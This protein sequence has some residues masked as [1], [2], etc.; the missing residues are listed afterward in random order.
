MAIY[1]ST[2][3]QNKYIKEQVLKLVLNGS[4]SHQNF[5]RIL[6]AYPCRLYTPNYFIR[7]A[8]GVL[9]I[10]AAIFSGLLIGLFFESS[11]QAALTGLFLFYSVVTYLIL[12]MLV[13]RKHYFNA[14]V[15]NL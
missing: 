3:L 8:L 1:T 10:I 11:G 6:S 7:I 5:A 12:E 13:R 4:I 9:T 2:D 14:G 15:D